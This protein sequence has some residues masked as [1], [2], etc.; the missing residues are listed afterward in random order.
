MKTTYQNKFLIYSIL[1]IISSRR[2]EDGPAISFRSVFKRVEGTYDVVK[3]EV[4]GADST[5][6]VLANLC[7]G[8]I[9]F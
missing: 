1:L 6:A 4:G 9:T 5:Y 7:Y 3:F 8:K 2:Y